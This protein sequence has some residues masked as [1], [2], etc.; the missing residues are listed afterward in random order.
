MKSKITP[1]YI[2]LIHDATLKSFWR[3]KTLRS[4]LRE[5]KISDQFL[6]TW[7][8]DESKRDFLSR[9]FNAL[10]RT[11]KGRDVLVKMAEYLSEQRSF[12]D[13]QNWEDSAN[14]ISD[15]HVSVNK[16]R[17]YHKQQDEELQSE[18]EFLKAKSRFA[19]NQAKVSISQITL[20][21]LNERLTE[22]VN[23]IG[24]SKGGYAFQAWFY[25]LMDFYEIQN[26]RPYSHEGRQIDGSIT[27]S[28]TTYLVELKFTGDKSG[29]P[30][31]DSLYKKVTTKADNTM[32]IM[33]SLSGYSSVAIKEASAS[34]T[35]LL[36]FDYTHMYLAL[37]GAMSFSEIIERVRRHASQT[38]EAYLDVK[39]FNS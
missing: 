33:V 35:P 13:L 2:S 17:I 12:P 39:Q 18:E 1:Y 14:K 27:L 34:R 9:L 6:A 22:L 30:D 5:C 25:D 4:F 32:G 23:D 36:L 38:G 21:K 37:G 26:R 8:E 11:D 19:E 28:G 24:T 3:K 31:I 7:N 15:A 29:A 16:L 20:G 10:P